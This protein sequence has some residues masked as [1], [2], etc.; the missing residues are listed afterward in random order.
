[1]TCLLLYKTQNTLSNHVFLEQIFCFLG[2]YSLCY[3]NGIKGKK[4]LLV[5]QNYNALFTCGEFIQILL[6]K[7]KNMVNSIDS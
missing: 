2:S 6:K 4:N 7:L 3:K 5:G 1:M